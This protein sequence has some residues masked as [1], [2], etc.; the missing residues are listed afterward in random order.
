MDCDA[1]SE[2]GVEVATSVLLNAAHDSN[3]AE[4]LRRRALREP[5]GSAL[6][7]QV[8]HF[9]VQSAYVVRK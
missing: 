1:S 9:V 7:F 4:G 5:W 2:L 6:T 3:V 8:L